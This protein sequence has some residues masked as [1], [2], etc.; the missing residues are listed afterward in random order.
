MYLVVL[1]LVVVVVVLIVN[2]KLFWMCYRIK[3]MSTYIE[4]SSPPGTF[5]HIILFCFL[6]HIYYFL[7]HFFIYVFTCLFNVHIAPAPIP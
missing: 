4:Q 6:H 5:Y 2:F 7:K 3:Q 1:L